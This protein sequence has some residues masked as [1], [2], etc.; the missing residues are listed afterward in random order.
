MSYS[1]FLHFSWCSWDNKAG[2]SRSWEWRHLDSSLSSLLDLP[3]DFGL[4]IAF[5]PSSSFLPPHCLTSPLHFSFS[6]PA[7]HWPH[8]HGLPWWCVYHGMWIFL[9]QMFP[10]KVY[11]NLI[12]IFSPDILS[13]TFYCISPLPLHFEGHHAMA[14]LKEDRDHLVQVHLFPNEAQR[15][16]IGLDNFPPAWSC[17]GITGRSC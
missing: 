12:F 8:L 15:K 4:S 2:W 11:I 10:I 16:R 1:C 7:R 13:R 17:P 3:W 14:G 6:S 5:L 9:R